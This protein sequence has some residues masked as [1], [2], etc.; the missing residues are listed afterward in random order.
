MRGK[1]KYTVLTSSVNWSASRTGLALDRKIHSKF[2]PTLLHKTQF[3]DTLIYLQ[4]CKYS[5]S[6]KLVVTAAYKYKDV[7]SKNPL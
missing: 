6:Q 4:F 7:A 1:F 3:V 5:H 2:S